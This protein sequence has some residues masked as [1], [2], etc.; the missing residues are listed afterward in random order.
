MK[1]KVS[2]RENMINRLKSFDSDEKMRQT[3]EVIAQLTSSVSWL[4]ADKVGLFY[5]M[6]FEFRLTGLFRSEK[7]IFL[8]KCLPK[9]QMIFL[10][11]ERKDK[12]VKSSWGLMEPAGGPDEQEKALDLIIVPGLAWNDAGYRIGFGGGYYDRFL[13]D[14]KGKTISLSYDFQRADFTPEPFDIPIGE[15]LRV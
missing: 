3:K 10:P 15:V 2:V 6:A 11:Y 9:R 1:N 4:T 14:F 12:L 8:P 13:A 7:K 5:P